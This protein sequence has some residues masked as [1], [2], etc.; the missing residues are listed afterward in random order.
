M[1]AKLSQIERQ[2]GSAPRRS[3]GTVLVT[4]DRF[5]A[6]SDIA[7][8]RSAGF[9]V[10]RLRDTG[11]RAAV[12]KAVAGKRGYIW[13]GMEVV[14]REVLAAAD[15][16]EAI[17]FPGSGYTEFI[18][19]HEEATRRGIAISTARGANAPSVAEYA[20]ALMMAMVRNLPT[21]LNGCGSHLLTPAPQKPGT[22]VERANARRRGI[23][24][25]R[26]ASCQRCPRTGNG[27]CRG[28]SSSPELARLCGR[29]P[30]NA[31]RPGRRC[32]PP[33]RCGARSPCFRPQGVGRDEAQRATGECCVS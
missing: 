10:S 19:A 20:L 21:T 2:A 33:R 23:W 27:R 11:D 16:L 18:T 15:S 12:I 28:G 26:A 30:R 6:T 4:G 17:A 1:R 25:H 5:V 24:Q 31:P 29:K 13:G 8:L 7:M 22:R 14:D 9:H 3:G 32:L